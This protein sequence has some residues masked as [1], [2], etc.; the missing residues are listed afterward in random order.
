M[1]LLELHLRNIASIER[2]DIDFEKDPGLIDPDTQQ[3]AQ[4]FLICGDT[5]TGKS[6]LLDGIAMALFKDTPRLN[7]TAEKIHN[8]YTSSHGK[9]ESIAGLGQ[10]TRMGISSDDPCY[11]EVVFEGKDAQQYTARLTL[12]ITKEGQYRTPA[13]SVTCNGVRLTQVSQCKEA[14]TKAIDMNFDQ[15]VRM[16]MLAQGEFTA[17]LCGKRDERAKVLEKL[18][19]TTIFNEYGDAISAL[20]SRKKE[21]CKLVE[22]RIGGIDEIMMKPD[23]V[24]ELQQRQQQLTP[25]VKET[26]Q[27]R[28]S[29]ETHLH[30]CEQLHSERQKQQD[31]AQKLQALTNESQSDANRQRRQLVE[32]WDRTVDERRALKEL[33][34]ATNE[35]KTIAES[36]I[37]QEE[38]FDVL[39]AD[40]QWREADLQ[41]RQQALAQEQQWLE[42][43]SDRDGLYAEAPKTL[44]QLDELSKQRAS[45]K[46]LADERQKALDRLPS[47][48]EEHRKADEQL[49][50]IEEKRKALQQLADDASQQYDKLNPTELDTRLNTLKKRDEAYDRL[51]TDHSNLQQK[52]ADLQK[53]QES[54]DSTEDDWNKA[55]SAAAKA[56]QQAENDQRQ[57]DEAM[58][59][60]TT[61]KASLDDTLS[62]L[63]SQMVKNHVETCPLCGQHIAH[64]LMDEQHFQAIVQPLELERQKAKTALDASRKQQEQANNEKSLLEGRRKAISEQLKQNAQTIAL[65]EAAMQQRLEKADIKATEEIAEAIRRHREE[66]SAQIQSV[67]EQKEKAAALHKKWQKQLDAMK[68]VDKERATAMEKTAQ[69]KSDEERCQSDIA[70][71]DKRIAEADKEI[72]ER[73]QLLEGRLAQWYGAQWSDTLQQVAETLNRE[74]TAYNNRKKACEGERSLLE[75]YQ[76]SIHNMTLQRNQLQERHPHWTGKAVAARCNDSDLMAR[77]QQL[78]NDS[79]ATSAR[80]ESCNANAKRCQE[81]LSAWQ[82]STG[83]EVR[84]LEQLATQE[85]QVPP[86]REQLEQLENDIRQQRITH[87]NAADEV[88]KICAKLDIATD[89]PL[90]HLEQ[91]QQQLAEIRSNEEALL[92]ELGDVQSKLKSH[93]ENQAKLAAVKQELEA[94]QAARD[95]WSIID[96]YFGGN[97]FRNLVQTHILR[98]LL[99]NANIYLKQISDRYTLTC[100]ADNEQLAIL[101]L[102][103]YNRNEVRSATILSGGERF[104]ISLALSLALSSL[105][106]PDLNFNILFIDE[107]FGT[108]DQECLDS[109]MNTLSR[110]TQIPGQTER[111]VGIISHRE[112]LLSRLPNKIKLKRAG[113]GRSTVEVVYE[114]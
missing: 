104:M 27:K 88:S 51:N 15:F 59:R 87:N 57:Y 114:N 22:S 79:I 74:A 96:K 37:R 40:L 42:Q 102:D 61:V 9:S 100:S 25:I 97:R 3:P 71:N 20:Y 62:Q 35:L 63:R 55:S 7:S 39:Q 84:Y 98:P 92:T 18:T 72:G 99:N 36:E 45:R 50:Q 12:G 6:V 24:L 107:G 93:E 77:W 4:K 21:A 13:W 34:Q 38:A 60:Y 48:Q 33:E 82:L 90:P 103:G 58:S 43:H 75:S 91:L 52:K 65:E 41:Q 14:I 16:S 2:A 113:Q 73:T 89:A 78:T 53:L 8:T 64:S 46:T 29:A 95:H 76:V 67:E 10:Y 54:L 17:F 28:Q 26:A 106:R 47:L 94:A 101:V 1:K 105:N 83:K 112:E 81:L 111:R 49:K 56:Q 86:A 66:L 44:S 110:L 11:S 32:D 5:G 23:E 109:V 68:P 85:Q 19:K 31:A 80:K 69:A 30:T 70:N 108:L